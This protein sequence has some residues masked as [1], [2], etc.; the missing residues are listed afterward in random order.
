[1]NA[2]KSMRSSWLKTI[3]CLLLLSAIVPISCQKDEVEPISDPPAIMGFTPSS[4]SE[5]TI[6]T[7]TG[8][9]FGTSTSS[10]TV[11]FNGVN[12]SIMSVSDT[13]IVTAVPV[14]ATTGP[15]TVVVSEASVTSSA[16][17]TV[18]EATDAAPTITS[19]TPTSGAAGT[20][21]IITGTNFSATASDNTVSFNGTTAV[22]S[23]ATATSLTVVVP[24]GAST[25]KITVTVA[26]NT[27]TSA[28]DFTVI[29][30]ATSSCEDAT[31]VGEK[32][33]CL[34][35]EFIASLSTTQANAVQLDFSAT[36]AVRWSNLPGG[37]TIRNGLEFSELSDEQ[38]VLAKAVIAAAS[39]SGANQ[40]YNEFLQINAAD[41][42]LKNQGGGGGPGGGYSSELYIIAFLGT[43]G[44]SGTWM[45]Q[46]GGHHY[47]QNITFENGEIVGPTPSHQGVEPLTWTANST[48]YAPLKDE[49]TAMAAMLAGLSTSELS[50]AKI[51]T[52][53]SDVVLG[54]GNDGKFP[55]TKVGLSVSGLSTTQKELVLAAMNAWVGDIEDEASAKL[56]DIY[57]S[58]LDA[59]YIAYSGNAS[60]TN[61]ADYVRIDGPSVWIEFI[62]QNGVV[63]SGIHYHTVY[64]DHTR[65]YGGN[66]SF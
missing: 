51:S 39:G 2:K 9:N 65:D 49:H 29:T 26:G 61:H 41:D 56:M 62:C 10:V 4:G 22:V 24:N 27:A 53:Y 18:I 52:S 21:V 66:F 31:T 60:L 12:A 63:L 48:T 13:E 15:I 25:G 38:L 46:F 43:P 32:V 55:D 11:S 42:Y 1:M 30:E 28:S 64:R 19:F 3:T 44:T 16:D 59:T 58:E 37:V 57:E 36:N 23:T 8:A 40:G 54:P 14:G 5:G 6:V 7:I 20:E 47:A 35:N 17:F 33:V 45:L 34:A 50:A